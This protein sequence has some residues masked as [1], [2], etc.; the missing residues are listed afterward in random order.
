[1]FGVV[2][3]GGCVGWGLV[4][5]GW[6]GVWWW[7]FGVVLVFGVVFGGGCVGWCLVVGVW[8][9]VWWWVVG[10]VFGGVWAKYP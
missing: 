8:G 10:V 3:G 6:G 1:M 9:G 2:F 5:G 7:V 4:V